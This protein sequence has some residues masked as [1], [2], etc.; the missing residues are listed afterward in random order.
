MLLFARL[1][2][3]AYIFLGRL[4]CNSVSGEDAGGLLMLPMQLLDSA[5]LNGS[6]DVAGLLMHAQGEAG[7]A[8][9]RAAP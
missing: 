7:A 8:L 6:L 4:A 2:R 9:V 5:A 1:P 3:G